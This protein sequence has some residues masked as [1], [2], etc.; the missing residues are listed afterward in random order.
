GLRAGQ[1]PGALGARAPDGREGGARFLPAPARGVHDAPTP[2]LAGG[3]AAGVAVHGR[4]PAPAAA[5]AAR[6]ASVATTA[7]R[8][9]G[10]FHFDLATIDVLTIEAR[11]RLLSVLLTGHLHEA[12]AA[13]PAGVAIGHDASRFDAAVGGEDL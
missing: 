9:L 12:E 5:A 7:L 11:H 6:A 1:S 13:R 4:L 2:P 10:Y 3:R 8:G